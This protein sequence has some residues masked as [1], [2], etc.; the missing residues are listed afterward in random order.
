[1]ISDGD[2]DEHEHDKDIEYDNGDQFLQ[3]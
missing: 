3:L 2:E 1:M